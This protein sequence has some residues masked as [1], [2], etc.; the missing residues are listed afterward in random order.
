VLEVEPTPRGS[1]R[2]FDDNGVDLTLVRKMLRR[3][4]E[5][6][7]RCVQE[8]VEEI[9]EIWKLNGTRPVR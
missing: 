5:E 9:L 4:P 8:M 3:S 6:R 7:L 2:D 1:E